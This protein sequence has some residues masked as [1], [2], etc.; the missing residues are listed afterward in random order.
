[1]T[2]GNDAEIRSGTEIG[3]VT[4]RPMTFSVRSDR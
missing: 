4:L 1:L 3:M 2:K